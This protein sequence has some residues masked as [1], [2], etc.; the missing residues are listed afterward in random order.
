[1]NFKE[2][3]QQDFS[4]FFNTNEFADDAIYIS[5]QVETPVKVIFEKCETNIKGNL[6]VSSGL[7]DS[8]SFWVML[9]QTPKTNDKI[10][11][12]ETDYTV[13]RIVEQNCNTFKVETISNE[14][15]FA[16]FKR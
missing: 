11:Y 7:S 15:P 2:I 16:N 9:N 14:Q 1:M 12:K 8:Y 6:I 3:M 5:K 13:K 10:R 4:T